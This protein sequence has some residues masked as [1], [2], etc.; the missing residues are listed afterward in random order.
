MRGFKVACG[1]ISTVVCILPP[2]RESGVAP[3][4]GVQRNPLCGGARRLPF[5][6][7]ARNA[8]LTLDGKA[9]GLRA[10]R[11]GC[12]LGCRALEFGEHFLD[13]SGHHTFGHAQMPRARPH[14]LFLVH[15]DRYNA[16]LV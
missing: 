3:R 6:L 8:A 13:V 5:E 4:A 15:R 11:F 16:F 10:F 9:H 1:Q 7:A 2:E 12:K 14:G